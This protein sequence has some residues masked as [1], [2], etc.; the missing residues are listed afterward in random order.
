[1]LPCRKVGDMGYLIWSKVI[2]CMLCELRWY[3]LW[4]LCDIDFNCDKK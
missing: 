2:K 4:L 3:W 1:M